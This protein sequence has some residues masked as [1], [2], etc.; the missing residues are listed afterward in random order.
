MPCP[1]RFRPGS[2]CDSSGDKTGS[3]HLQ[4]HGRGQAATEGQGPGPAQ[5]ASLWAPCPQPTRDTFP[6]ASDAPERALP[7]LLSGRCGQARSR[8]SRRP[9]Q[10]ISAPGPDA[11]GPP[12]AQLPGPA[13]TAPASQD[14][15]RL[16]PSAVPPRA[17]RPRPPEAPAAKGLRGSRPPT[18][19]VPAARPRAHSHA[20]TPGKV[21]PGAGGGAASPHLWRTGRPG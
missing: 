16:R 18:P 6:A 5:K 1:H 11:R 2:C 19:S 14:S 15:S 17:A 9:R 3:A 21:R 8:P 13:S 7:S 10:G 20:R 4:G 12:S